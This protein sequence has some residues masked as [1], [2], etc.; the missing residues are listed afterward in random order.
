MQDPLQILLH[1]LLYTLLR[2]LVHPLFTHTLVGLDSSAGSAAT[3][4]DLEIEFG[5]EIQALAQ[6]IVLSNGTFS[7]RILNVKHSD[8]GG[9]RDLGKEFCRITESIP[10]R[11]YYICVIQQEGGGVGEHYV[12]ERVCEGVHSK[13]VD[14]CP[15]KEHVY[16]GNVEFPPYPSSEFNSIEEW[17]EVIIDLLGSTFLGNTDLTAV[18]A[19]SD[20]IAKLVYTAAL[21]YHPAGEVYISGFDDDATGRELLRQ[22]ALWGTIDVQ[23]YKPGRGLQKTL[24]R[25]LPIILLAEEQL[26]MAFRGVRAYSLTELYVPDM[27]AK[28]QDRLLR[29]YDKSVKPIGNVIVQTGMQDV[30]IYEAN[31]REGRF[32]AVFWMTRLWR[33]TRLSWDPVIYD[34]LIRVDADDVWRPAYYYNNLYETDDVDLYR[35]PATINSSGFVNIVTNQRG[36]FLCEGSILLFPFDHSACS[37][38][39]ISVQRSIYFNGDLGFGI[40]DPDDA[41]VM[42]PDEDPF[43]E[44]APFGYGYEE[45]GHLAG[46]LFYVTNGQVAYSDGNYTQVTYSFC[47]ARNPNSFWIRLII[48]ALLLNGIGFMAFWIPDPNESIALGITTLL[49]TLALR[50]TVEL[51]DK[52]FFTWVELFLLLNILFQGLVLLFSFCDYSDALRKRLK[53]LGHGVTATLRCLRSF[54]R[55]HY[56]EKMRG[57]LHKLRGRGGKT[58]VPP[59]VQ[60]A[61]AVVAPAAFVDLDSIEFSREHRSPSGVAAPIAHPATTNEQFD[62]V[63]QLSEHVRALS[64]KLHALE[65]QSRAQSEVGYAYAS[66]PK[67]GDTKSVLTQFSAG[68]GASLQNLIPG[69]GRKDL[70][71]S[72]GRSVAPSLPPSPPE[73]VLWA[74]STPQHASLTVPEWLATLDLG[75][76]TAMFAKEFKSLE[77]VAAPPPHA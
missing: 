74:A 72:P 69:V 26:P 24:S 22:Y 29:S 46:G 45:G 23:Y 59:S 8:Y 71:L 70:S 75:S 21:R 57:K 11:Q 6:S 7:P 16:V 31:M 33:D 34:G 13:I 15:E 19:P 54:D 28:V 60:P 14:Y 17:E 43:A 35:S 47:L 64:G 50:D 55:A 12:S 73:T 52:S 36:T 40:I 49:C 27:E 66:T 51:P 41:Y 3:G 67:D 20:Q 68:L 42:P 18:V 39:L 53:A 1:P 2:N 61:A 77:Q 9:A 76:H 25:V 38:N 10:A 62:Q 32:E 48:P 37:I 58:Q 65:A 56:S 5:P 44:R 4:A 63:S 30:T